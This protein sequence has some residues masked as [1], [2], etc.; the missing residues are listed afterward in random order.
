MAGSGA[1]TA[2]DGCKCGMWGA[3]SRLVCCFRAVHGSS[4][5]PRKKKSGWDAEE[6]TSAACG[7]APSRWKT[8][9]T[10]GAHLAVRGAAG[11]SCR[12]RKERSRAGAAR[13]FCRPC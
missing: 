4:A 13:T 11:P 1:T 8:K 5:G 6:L 3:P 12:R 2:G 7:G 10:S 9:L